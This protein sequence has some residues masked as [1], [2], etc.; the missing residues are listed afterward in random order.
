L[1]SL[2]L[3][4]RLKEAAAIDERLRLARELHDSLLQSVAGSALKLLAA[5]RLLSREPEA[6]RQRL[7]EVQVQLERG[8]LE[9]RSFIGR[10]RPLP[11][12]A[13]VIGAGL[14][15][16]LQQLRK[17]IELEWDVKVKLH[18]GSGADTWP[19]AVAIEVYRI[20]QEAVLNA[21][22]HADASLIKV[23]VTSAGG[24]CVEVVDD[25]CG[26]PFRGTYDLRTLNDM[27]LGPL[28][29]RERVAGLNGDLHLRT[30]S[31]GTGL[32]IRLPPAKATA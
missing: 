6:A 24:P 4:K 7:E 10:L 21:A 14:E 18:I 19:E 2:H 3:L 20:V 26:F 15:Q 22:R 32:L 29:L 30:S 31:S 9:M 17:R 28:T 8:E 25:G 13:P 16:R 12:L 23:N 27:N 5:R 1:D 11:L